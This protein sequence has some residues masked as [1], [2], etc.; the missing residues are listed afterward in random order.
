MQQELAKLAASRAAAAADASAA[1]N[2]ADQLAAL[3]KEQVEA[4]E[5]LAKLAQAVAA[6]AAEAQAA[7]A[8]VAV[9]AAQHKSEQDGRQ[10]LLASLAELR[11]E[12][13]R[14]VHLP[15]NGCPPFL[16]SILRCN[17]FPRRVR[18]ERS[19]RL[20]AAGNRQGSGIGDGR[21][22]EERTPSALQEGLRSPGR[23][24]DRLCLRLTGGAPAVQLLHHRPHASWS[25][26]ARMDL[27]AVACKNHITSPPARLLRQAH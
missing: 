7:R 22:D 8:E 1:S 19:P 14:A 2:S 13:R 17:R 9:A 15:L 25:L 6:A 11:A 4:R 3:L 21:S 5:G 18:V 23:G 12:V 26:R 24:R 20:S 10:T 16:A 27:Q